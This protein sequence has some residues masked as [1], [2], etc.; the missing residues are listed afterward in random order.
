MKAR[1]SPPPKHLPFALV[2]KGAKGLR[3]AAVNEMARSFGLHRGQRL[4]DAR[5]QVPDLLSEIAEPEKDAASLLG[6]CQWLE[7][8]SPWVAPDPPDGILL[9]V[10]GIPHL[11]GGEDAMLADMRSRLGTYGF[12][13]RTA[14]APTIGAAWG[15]ARYGGESSSLEALPIEALRID[16]AHAHTLRCL[17]LRTVGALMHIPRASLARR[18]RGETI[19]ENVLTRLDEALGV[20]DEPLNPLNPP[21]SFMAH[22]AFMEPVITPEGLDAVLT[23]LVHHLCRDLEAKAQGA[24]RLILRLFRSD[25]ARIS[26]PAG[27][28]APSHEATH[29]LRLLR[30]RLEGIDAGFGIDAMTLE[31]RET[32]PAIIRQ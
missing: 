28:S 5:A 7:R 23:G 32:A 31:A 9:D 27:L 14:I 3:L 10:T 6:L 2:E 17:G 15:L 26:L 22:R 21:S 25:G 13:A 11:F 29:L 4:A 8:Y 20:R 12:T 24:L 18:F 30:P 1:R 16:A 19:A